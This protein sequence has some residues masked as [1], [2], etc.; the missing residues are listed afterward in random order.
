[1]AVQQAVHRVVVT[2]VD[3]KDSVPVGVVVRWWWFVL[4][5]SVVSNLQAS[6]EKQRIYA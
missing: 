4:Q 3:A 6:R 1:M 2:L 5:E